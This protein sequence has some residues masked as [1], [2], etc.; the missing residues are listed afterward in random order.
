M[1]Y[2]PW[3]FEPTR[4]LH[5]LFLDKFGK[6]WENKLPIEDFDGHLYITKESVISI[7]GYAD[8]SEDQTLYDTLGYPALTLSSFCEFVDEIQDKFIIPDSERILM[9][10][11][12]KSEI[13]EKIAKELKHFAVDNWNEPQKIINEV[14]KYL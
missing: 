5:D 6:V 9:N 2:E 8:Y 14:K 4:E 7:F 1:T 3:A 12:L 10:I 13:Q 11:W